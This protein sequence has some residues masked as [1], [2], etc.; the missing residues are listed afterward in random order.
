MGIPAQSLNILLKTSHLR[1]VRQLGQTAGSMGN[2][3]SSLLLSY[4]YKIFEPRAGQLGTRQ[5]SSNMPLSVSKCEHSKWYAGKMGCYSYCK[6]IAVGYN[7][8]GSI[9][10][11]ISPMNRNVEVHVFATASV[12]KW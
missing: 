6:P 3:N 2:L 5:G 4:R 10:A 11:D 7:R 9:R 1:L 8:E 12:F